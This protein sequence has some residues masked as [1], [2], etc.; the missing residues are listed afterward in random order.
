MPIVGMPDGTQVQFP[1]EMP[2]DQIKGLIAQKFPDQVQKVQKE[3]GPVQAA[4]H[5][6]AQGL[7][8]NFSDELA[9]LHAASGIPGGPG[10][11]PISIPVGAARLAYEYLTQPGSATQGYEQARNA[12]RGAN[13]AA[14]EQQPIAHTVG[15]VGGAVA[16]PLG[17]ALNAATLPARMARGAAVGA[18][19]GAASGLG[20]GE[21]VPQ[22]VTKGVSG[23]VVGG[24]LGGAGVPVIEKGA[25]AV[26]YLAQ[27]PI[28]LIRGAF[29]PEKEALR[30]IGVAEQRAARVDPNAENRLNPS[31]IT[32]GS[33]AVIDVLGSPGRDLARAAA[34]RSPE[35]RDVLNQTLDPRFTQQAPRFVNWFKSTLNHPDQ[36]VQQEAIETAAKAANRPAYMKAYSKGDRAIWSPELERLTGSPAVQDAMGGATRRWRDFAIAD[37]YGAMNPGAMVERGG[38]LEML[39]GKVPVFPNI[40]FWDYTKRVIDGKINEALK[41][42]NK[43]DAAVWSNISGQLRGELDKLSPSYADARAGAAKFFKAEN[44]LE[45]GQNFVTEPFAI[46][47]A[48]KALSKM[49][50]DEKKLFEDGFRQRYAQIISKIP[51]T[52]DITIRVYQSDD[53]RQRIGM[54]LG[55]QKA[56][57]LEAMLRI[58]GI[59]QKGR[60]AVQGGSNT[61]TQ[62]LAQG[63]AGF[64]AGFAGG[65]VLGYDPSTTGVIAATLAGGRVAVDRRVA[66]ELAKLLTSNDPAVLQKAAKIAAGSPTI[67]NALRN[68]SVRVAGQQSPNIPAIEARTVG[69]AQEDQQPVPG[70]TAP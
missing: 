53:A 43:T 64:G 67:M 17:G 42:G 39:H 49:T 37:G 60:A 62:L 68:A 63:G 52:N 46:P 20:E 56:D 54:V 38:I 19:S 13:K 70:P 26:G 55:K 50:P 6:A 1:D 65:G 22:R 30:R 29:N 48:R 51:D 27:K 36:V 32:G 41:S 16:V 58:E 23:A 18:A 69:R 3:M 11:S 4:L 28:G 35:A 66:N 45:A 47:E 59:M 61:A 34:N 57:E 5:G 31:E 24:A 40:Q 9:G 2:A 25:Q 12:V 10:V 7:S 33:E 15:E 44:A 14:T 21:T 8:A